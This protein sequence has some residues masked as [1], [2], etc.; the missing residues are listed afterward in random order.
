MPLPSIMGSS[1]AY[2]VT[3]FCHTSMPIP[4]AMT[5]NYVSST[6]RSNNLRVAENTERASKITSNKYHEILLKMEV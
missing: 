6:E 2:V 5:Y 3:A 4:L 1:A